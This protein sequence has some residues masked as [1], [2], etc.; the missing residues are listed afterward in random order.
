MTMAAPLDERAATK[1]DRYEH[2]ERWVEKNA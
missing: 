2:D 1:D